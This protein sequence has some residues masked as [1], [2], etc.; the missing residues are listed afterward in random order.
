MRYAGLSF[1]WLPTTRKA[2]RTESH[3]NKLTLFCKTVKLLNNSCIES[4]CRLYIEDLR[5]DP[6]ECMDDTLLNTGSEGGD[7][8]RGRGWSEEESGTEEAA[9]WHRGRGRER[10]KC[11]KGKQANP[12]KKMHFSSLQAWTVG[13]HGK[14]LKPAAADRVDPISCFAWALDWT[15]SE[16]GRALLRRRCNSNVA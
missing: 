9:L 7:G 13:V 1:D 14:L 4:D 10:E 2:G 16:G 6:H 5:K 12:R 8:G 11:R 3:N 15:V